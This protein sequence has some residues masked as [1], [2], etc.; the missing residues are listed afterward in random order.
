MT[1][2]LGELKLSNEKRNSPRPLK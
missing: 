2:N 1:N